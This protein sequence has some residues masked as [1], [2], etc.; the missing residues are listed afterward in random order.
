MNI[1]I[2]S[3]PDQWADYLWPRRLTVKSSPS[4][5]RWT[6]WVWSFDKRVK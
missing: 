1:Q 2:H 5:W 3:R 4:I 6:F